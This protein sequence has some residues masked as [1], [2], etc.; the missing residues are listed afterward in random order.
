MLGHGNQRY[1]DG[2]QGV[3]RE[4]QRLASKDLTD[5]ADMIYIV[6]GQVAA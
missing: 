3:S 4:A 5:L 2:Q 1:T 6:G